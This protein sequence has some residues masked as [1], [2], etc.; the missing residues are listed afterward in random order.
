ML[1]TWEMAVE[2]LATYPEEPAKNAVMDDVPTGSTVVAQVAMPGSLTGTL[3]EPQIDDAPRFERRP[4]PSVG[5][6]PGAVT[7]HTSRSA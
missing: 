7:E 5:P 3:A 6:V 2:P 4:L 1:T